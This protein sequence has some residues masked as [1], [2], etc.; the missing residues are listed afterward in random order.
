MKMSWAVGSV[1]L[2]YLTNASL[3]TKLAM[4]SDMAAMPRRLAAL[5]GE[6]VTRRC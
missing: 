5:S 6:W 4:A 2:T 3:V 1:W